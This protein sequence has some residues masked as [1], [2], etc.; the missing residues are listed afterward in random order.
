M[1]APSVPHVPDRVVLAVDPSAA[2]LHAA[3][4]AA[5]HKCITPADDV[6]LVSVVPSPPLAPLAPGVAG[7]GGLT[8]TTGMKEYQDEWRATRELHRATLDELFNELIKRGAVAPEKC[9]RVLL[10]GD[11]AGGGAV[12][13][14]VVNY[15]RANGATHLVLG[16]RGL[17]AFKR[18]MYA[19]IG[20]GSVS[21]HVVRHAPCAVT[22]VPHESA[23]T[24][25]TV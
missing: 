16:S 20:L 6:R 23:P 21:D 13:D 12:G 1:A 25:A 8:S 11:G 10:D 15:A 3:R 19:L 17:S 24:A 2:S 9:A 5:A 22:V 4:W 18:G 14:P 7:V